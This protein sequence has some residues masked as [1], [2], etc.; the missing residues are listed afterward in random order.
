MRVLQIPVR[1][2]ESLLRR[3]VLGGEVLL[4]AEFTIIIIDVVLG[5]LDLCLHVPV[6]RLERVE[7]VAHDPDLRVGALQCEPEREI[8]QAEQHLAIFDVL[9][10]L[11]VDLLDH[12]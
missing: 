12:A 3:D 1:R 9:V 8:V 7:I 5:L 6:V 4:P 11:D 10:V 2:V